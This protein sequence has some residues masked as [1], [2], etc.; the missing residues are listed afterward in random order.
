Y[1]NFDFASG[2]ISNEAI[3]RQIKDAVAKL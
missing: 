1:D 2:S 3:A